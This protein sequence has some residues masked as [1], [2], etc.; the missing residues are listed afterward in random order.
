MPGI[1][2]TAPRQSA[3][4]WQPWSGW[5]VGSP[6]TTRLK[7]LF[8]HLVLN[9]CSFGFSH[10]HQWAPV[11]FQERDWANW[12]LTMHYC[13]ISRTLGATKKFHGVIQFRILSHTA[14]YHTMSY[15][16]SCF[17]TLH[18]RVYR[19]LVTRAHTQS[20]HVH[21]LVSCPQCWN[22]KAKENKTAVAF[23]D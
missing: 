5:A 16:I 20:H 12:R 17:T 14:L 23:H 15:I 4:F 13:I 11:F 22:Y 6:V 9:I 21:F 8:A 7:Q 1:L 18:A 2:R 19:N 3:E 10:S